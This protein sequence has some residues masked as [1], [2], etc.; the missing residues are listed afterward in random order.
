MSELRAF[1]IYE[2]RE[3]WCIEPT[4]IDAGYSKDRAAKTRAYSRLSQL[5]FHLNGRV[6]Q[7]DRD[8]SS[9]P[10]GAGSS[11][12]APTKNATEL[13]EVMKGLREI[14]DAAAPE[15]SES[16]FSVHADMLISQAK[17]PSDGG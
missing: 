11:P 6:N 12:A 5:T 16:P 2:C 9:K 4:K 1:L 7:Q 14:I 17:Y 13:L 10:S 8:R 3:G 15:Y